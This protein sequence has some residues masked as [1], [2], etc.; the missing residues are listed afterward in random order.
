MF[1]AATAPVEAFA[2]ERGERWG[3]CESTADC[4]SLKCVEGR[5]IDPY[6]KEEPPPPH[7][8]QYFLGLVTIGGP[9][10]GGVISPGSRWDSALRGSYLVAL[11]AGVILAEKHEFAV[12]ISPFT[13]RYYDPAPG[14]TFQANATYGYRIPLYRGPSVL[15]YLPL[16]IGG[17]FFAGNVGGDVY[18]QLRFDV[19][20]AVHVG[21]F[22]VDVYAPSYRYAVTSVFGETANLLSWEFGA[23]GSYS[24]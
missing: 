3:P 2:Q 4:H 18:A 15:V 9:A 16:R 5:C 1:L 17:G 24:F 6:A 21:H 19:G 12:E 13:Y 11:R 14:P 10:F 20:V 8:T 7:A 22:I 23:G